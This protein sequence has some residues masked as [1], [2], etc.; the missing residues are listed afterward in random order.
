MVCNSGELDQYLSDA[1]EEGNGMDEEFNILGWWKVVGPYKYP[2][3][4]QIAKDLLA[5]LISSVA[6]ESAFSNGGRGLDNLK[7]SLLPSIVEALICT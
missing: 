3:L 4:S 7:S 2:T 5:I 1:R 6:S